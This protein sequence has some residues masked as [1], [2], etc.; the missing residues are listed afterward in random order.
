MSY[1]PQNF[2]KVPKELSFGIAHFKVTS[3]HSVR[4]FQ[5]ILGKIVIKSL[6]Q[7][8]ACCKHALLI[9]VT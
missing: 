4:N 3:S 6:K 2:L 5:K 1:K 9:I 7:G 8:L